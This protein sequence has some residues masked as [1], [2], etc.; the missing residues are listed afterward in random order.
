MIKPTNIVLCS[1][2]WGADDCGYLHYRVSHGQQDPFF[3][4]DSL[5]KVRNVLQPRNLFIQEHPLILIR[6]P[7]LLVLG[8]INNK[9]G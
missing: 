4:G 8:E 1:S 9:L 7:V 2:E 3:G 5:G 6:K